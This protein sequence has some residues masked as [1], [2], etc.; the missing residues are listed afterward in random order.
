MCR[1]VLIYFNLSLQ[2]KMI[3]FFYDNLKY[4]GFLVLGYHESIIGNS[5]VKY[6]RKHYY[7]SKK[8][9]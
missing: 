1:N 6:H 8:L 3:D 9:L 7:Y 5:A 2:N 4:P